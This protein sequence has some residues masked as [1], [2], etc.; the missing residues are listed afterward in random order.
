MLT[1]CSTPESPR[2][3]YVVRDF[4][5][6]I[7][8]ALVLVHP[9]FHEFYEASEYRESLLA[10]VALAK[11]SGTPVFHVPIEGKWDSLAAEIDALGLIPVPLA[12]F[13]YGVKSRVARRHQQK[14][15]DFLAGRIGKRPSQI[16]LALGGMYAEAC[17]FACAQSW[18]RD[19][20]PWWPGEVDAKTARFLPRRPIH[21]ADIVERITAGDPDEEFRLTG[22]PQRLAA[23]RKNR[24]RTQTD[25]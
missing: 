18:C 4:D 10:A 8:D 9:S 14:T 6:T 24:R 1:D 20:R 13:D 12:T 11:R 2:A 22:Y 16:R 21:Q 17:V 19:V 5:P 15:V 7:H 23:D 3:P 25:G